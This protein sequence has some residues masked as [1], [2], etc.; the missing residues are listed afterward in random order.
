MIPIDKTLFQFAQLSLSE[1]PV[2]VNLIV[3]FL[4]HGKA[5]F[6]SARLRLL[7]PRRMRFLRFDLSASEPKTESRRN[8]AGEFVLYSLSTSC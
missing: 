5:S 8:G 7:N 6:G 2:A 4:F 1:S 3:L